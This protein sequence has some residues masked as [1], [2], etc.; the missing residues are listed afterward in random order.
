MMADCAFAASTGAK[1]SVTRIM[2]NKFPHAAA[3]IRAEAPGML[4]YNFAAALPPP[5][6][7]SFEDM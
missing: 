6:S 2:P 4:A 5:D 1:A 7:F 3:A